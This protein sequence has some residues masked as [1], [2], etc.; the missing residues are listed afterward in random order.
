MFR[1]VT[2]MIHRFRSSRGQASSKELI[3]VLFS[4]CFYYL[5]L[6]ILRRSLR[7]LNGE[8]AICLPTV[9]SAF[10]HCSKKANKVLQRW[11]V[12]AYRIAP[13]FKSSLLTRGGH[14]QHKF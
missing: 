1:E 11:R 12:L 9:I 14:A 3:Q 5:P 7:C 8:N 13:C 2:K 4:L 10:H 6:I